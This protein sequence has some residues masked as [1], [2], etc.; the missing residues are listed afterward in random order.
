[1]I[2]LEN[3]GYNVS[4]YIYQSREVAMNR[5][6]LCNY[7]LINIKISSHPYSTTKYTTKIGVLLFSE[8]CQWLLLCKI[9]G[10]VWRRPYK[11]EDQQRTIFK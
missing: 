11:K 7:D 10:L 9:F 8:I 3:F 5:D 1:M 4:H 2:E 6:L